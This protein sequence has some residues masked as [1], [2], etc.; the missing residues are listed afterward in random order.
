VRAGNGG[1]EL[2]F[3][4]FNGSVRVLRTAP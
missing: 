2:T 3:E 1:P 4:T